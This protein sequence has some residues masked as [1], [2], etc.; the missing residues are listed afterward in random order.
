MSVEAPIATD[1]NL[2]IGEDRSLDFTVVDA[3][4]T[5]VDITS[6]GLEWVMRERAASATADITKTTSSGITLTDPTNGVCRVAIADT[7]T[8]ALLPGTYFHTL[9]RTDDDSETVLS[10]G[11]VILRYA[12]TR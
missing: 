12:A 8:L 11:D 7:D 9:R 6:Y 10:F 5:A 1:K 4:G 2:F 3:N